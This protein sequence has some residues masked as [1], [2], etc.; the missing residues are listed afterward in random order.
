MLCRSNK[1]YSVTHKSTHF[2]KGQK[3]W[4]FLNTSSNSE[5]RNDSFYFNSLF[6]TT[7][8]DALCDAF[9]ET[10]YDIVCDILCHIL[11]ERLLSRC[12]PI[13]DKRQ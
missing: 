12:N 2:K 1:N 4:L 3:Y 6:I 5:E 7:I 11:F 13:S 8:C 10:C 9:C